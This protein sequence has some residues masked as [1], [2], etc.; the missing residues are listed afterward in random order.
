MN[1]ADLEN[2]IFTDATAA[3]E[4]LERVLGPN[5]PVCPHCGERERLTKL[6]GKSHRPASTK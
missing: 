4:H 1:T 5:G 2:P 3:R 6:Q